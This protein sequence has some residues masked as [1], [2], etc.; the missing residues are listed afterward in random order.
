MLNYGKVKTQNVDCPICS[1]SPGQF[2][3]DIV[4]VQDYLNISRQ[5]EFRYYK[6]KCGVYYL[7]NQ[8]TAD[9]IAKIYSNNY[10]AYKINYGIVSKLK[11]LRMRSI[12]K[13]LLISGRQTKILDF[14]CGSGEFMFSISSL[15]DTSIVGY[16]FNSP[17]E[18]PKSN[19]IFVESKEEI[20]ALGKFDLIFSFQVIEHLNNPHQFLKYLSEKLSPN[21]RL[22]LETPSSSGILFSKL[23][24]I[25]WGGWHAPRHFVIF[26]KKSLIEL[27]KNSG[28]SVEKFQYIPSPFQ[29]IES[30]RPYISSDSKLNKILSLNNFLLVALFY[31]VDLLLILIRF[32]SSNMK[33]VLKKK[34]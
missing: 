29:W 31:G 9:Q 34:I 33:L 16:D 30:F 24:R 21:G 28:F 17:S 15:V 22:V 11:M 7:R 4:V 32:R 14:G 12:L 10:Q 19:M 2:S 1:K 8:P 3:N 25:N 18:P 26:N 13:P 6:C 27:C 23:I 20:D 5:Q